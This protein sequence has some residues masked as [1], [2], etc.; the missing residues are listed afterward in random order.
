MASKMTSRETPFS[1]E[2]ASATIRISL[3]IIIV[4]PYTRV[5]CPI[6]AVPSEHCRTNISERDVCLFDLL[7]GD[8]MQS[9][10]NGHH[11][12]AVLGFFKNTI[13]LASAIERSAQFHIDH[14][15]NKNQALFEF[16]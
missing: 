7:P 10:V 3:L 8:F 2:T 13:V 4:S 6:R 5:H 12:H 14:F 15:A 9:L 16:E 11:Q 1:L